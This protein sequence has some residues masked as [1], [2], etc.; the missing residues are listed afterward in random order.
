MNG[1]KKNMDTV[2]GKTCPKIFALTSDIDDQKVSYYN[3]A[4]F[5]KVYK[6]LTP[7]SL[8]QMLQQS[9]L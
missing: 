7:E 9:N 8:A 5:H 2:V 1:I 4:G 6:D 3:N